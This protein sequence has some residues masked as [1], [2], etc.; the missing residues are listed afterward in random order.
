RTARRARLLELVDHHVSIRLASHHLGNVVA[1]QVGGLYRGVARSVGAQ[2]AHI[3]EEG[4]TAHDSGPLP[5]I[6]PWLILPSV[7]TPSF[8]LPPEISRNMSSAPGCPSRSASCSGRDA[9]SPP[10]IDAPN[11]G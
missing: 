4:A 8:D 2:G 11:T 10:P 9:D 1:V 7:Q 5:P 3:R 6:G